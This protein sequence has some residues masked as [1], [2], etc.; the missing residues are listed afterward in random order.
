MFYNGVQKLPIIPCPPCTSPSLFSVAVPMALGLLLDRIFGERFAITTRW[1]ASGVTRGCR[2]ADRRVGVGRGV[3]LLAL[4]RGGA[5]VGCAGRLAEGRPTPGW[6]WRS[7]WV[8][9]ISRSAA[10][11]SPSTPVRSPAPLAAGDLL[12]RAKRLSW[13]VSRDTPSWTPPAS[14]KATVEIGA[15]KRQ[16]RDLWRAVLVCPAGRAGALMFRLANTLDAMWGYRNERYLRFG[17]AAARI[18]DVLNFIPARLTAL[19]Y[20]LLGHTAAA[21]RC[22]RARRPPGTAP[23]PV[24]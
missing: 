4:E 7:T 6:A 12:A 17:W 8:C 3:G 1:S 2:A 14:P 11:A 16:R 18:D 13:I 15:R 5:A 23:T 9:C 21:L 22:W 20:A 10:A 19:S 24:R